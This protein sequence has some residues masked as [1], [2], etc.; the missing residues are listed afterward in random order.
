MLVLLIDKHPALIKG[1]SMYL[2]E[3]F[4]AC[5]VV[6][7]DSIEKMETL[8][9]K[10]NPDII[11]TE[12]DFGKGGEALIEIK[13]LLSTQ[14]Q[15]N[16]IIYTSYCSQHLMEILLSKG[17]RAVVSKSSIVDLVAAVSATQKGKKFT[18][19]NTPKI[20]TS[21]IEQD[22]YILLDSRSFKIFISLANGSSIND[23]VREYRLSSRMVSYIKSN[24]KKRLAVK[25]DNELTKLAIRYGHIN[26][27]VAATG[28]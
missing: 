15:P 18:P 10:Y 4:A 26:V 25:E 23:L 14:P 6:S 5:Q 8:Y 28:K 11:I 3:G 19:I 7:A 24:I 16:I 21:G 1:V 17:V 13:S 9:L 22:P 20:V 2:R 27:G 12:I